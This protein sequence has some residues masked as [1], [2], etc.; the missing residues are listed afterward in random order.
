MLFSWNDLGHFQSPKANLKLIQERLA[1]TKDYNTY[2]KEKRNAK[3]PEK[4][5]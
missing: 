5:F 3:L 4:Q 2:D 1:P